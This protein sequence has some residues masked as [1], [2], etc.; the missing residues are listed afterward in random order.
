MTELVDLGKVDKWVA[1]FG[2]RRDRFREDIFEWGK[3]LNAGRVVLNDGEW[4]TTLTKA[5]LDHRHSQKCMRIARNEWLVRYV[6]HLPVCVS[7]LE[8]LAGLSEEN[9]DKLLENGDIHPA[10]TVAELREAVAALTKPKTEPEIKPVAV[11]ALRQEVDQT[12]TPAA[13]DNR[14][15]GAEA[16]NREYWEHYKENHVRLPNRHTLYSDLLIGDEV[17]RSELT[18]RHFDNAI[19]YLRKERVRVD[20]EIDER[21]AELERQR[22]RLT[23]S[24]L[25]V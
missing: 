13:E 3:L 7:A 25:D 10:A 19:K 16:E 21:M 15:I 6:A 20:A 22:N 4:L 17:L 1:K 14:V 11:A 5:K 18:P 9:Q 2:A 24:P 12:R 8:V 23:A